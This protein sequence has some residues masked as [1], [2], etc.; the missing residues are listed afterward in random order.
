[1]NDKRREAIVFYDERIKVA[2]SELDKFVGFLAKAPSDEFTKRQIQKT[3]ANIA[4]YEEQVESLK[5]D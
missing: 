4:E 3:E 2:R 5:K 1:M